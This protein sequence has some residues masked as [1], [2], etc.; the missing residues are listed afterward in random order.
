MDI[1]QWELWPE[2]LQ[3]DVRGQTEVDRCEIDQILHPKVQGP[4]QNHEEGG[5][6][7][8]VFK[9]E[10][11]EYGTWEEIDAGFDELRRLQLFAELR[12]WAVE[13]GR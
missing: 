7:F 3:A 12:R 8:W 11:G 2:V 13:E 4:G 9:E 6:D 10:G 5:K 1:E